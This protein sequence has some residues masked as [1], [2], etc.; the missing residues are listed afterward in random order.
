ML[1][2]QT[3]VYMGLWVDSF[4][5]SC[6]LFPLG[7]LTLLGL[8]RALCLGDVKT[9]SFEIFHSWK[10]IKTLFIICKPEPSKLCKKKVHLDTQNLDH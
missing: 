1:L 10:E 5:V 6:T 9:A 4:V 2:A 8:S 3:T 7:G